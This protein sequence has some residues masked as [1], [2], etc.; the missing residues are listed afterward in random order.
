MKKAKPCCA[1]NTCSWT[2]RPTPCGPAPPDPPRSARER[3]EGPRRD[4]FHRARAIDGAVSGCI[5]GVHLG[6][7]RVVV[8]QRARLSRVDLRPLL[9]SFCLVGLA[10]DQ[11]LARHVVETGN[12]G[13]IEL[14][15]V[16]AARGGV[17][18][19]PAHALDDGLEGN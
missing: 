16:R 12:L 3:R 1:P 13:W 18:S 4:F 6:P 9:D 17:R 2:A 14:H 19:A 15:V 7:V 5:D 11:R 10:L 8:R